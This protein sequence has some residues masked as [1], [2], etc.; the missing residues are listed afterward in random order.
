MNPIIRLGVSNTVFYLCSQ[1]SNLFINIYVYQDFH[2][3][4]IN[5]LYNA[6]MYA[7]WIVAFA[8]GTRISE[9]SAKW[10]LMISSLCGIGALA[11]L[12]A[13]PHRLYAD[14]LIAVVVGVSSGFYWVAYNVIFYVFSQ[15]GE[16]TRRMARFNLATGLIA[17][18][19]PTMS[20]YVIHFLGYDVAFS[21]VMMLFIVIFVLSL[22]FPTLSFRQH[23]A[24]QD[25]ALR[26]SGVTATGYALGVK[27]GVTPSLR[28][29]DSE[30][31]NDVEWNRKSGL[32]H[33]RE[34]MPAGF[35][36]FALALISGGYY[37][38]FIGFASGVLLYS[39][40]SGITGAGWM[41]T[42]YALF[43][44]GTTTLIGYGIRSSSDSR[45]QTYG[46]IGALAAT[47]GTSLLFSHHKAMLIGFNVV[48]SLAN[49]LF[50]SLLSAQQFDAVG[51][52]YPNVAR[53]FL[54]RESLYSVARIG[55]F[56]YVAIFGLQAGSVAYIIFVALLCSAPLVAVAWNLRITRI[57]S[58]LR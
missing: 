37:L 49:P 42:L 25:N 54:V 53:G 40:G 55:L 2:S 33:L 26:T 57:P 36:M 50:T 16:R 47:V 31:P 32:A 18:V 23:D 3:L 28:D 27:M 12:M 24:K 56:S 11:L 35:A 10:N 19:M 13:M 39:Y 8:V 6:I 20:A 52:L 34:W 45:R 41:N 15:T 5:G 29:D 4:R 44:A 1:F 43:S 46:W 48:V 51:T 22:G 9:R 17:I 58:V 21:I 14:L 7:A 30:I 38:N